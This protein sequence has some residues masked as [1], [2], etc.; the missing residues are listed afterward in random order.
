MQLFDKFE[1]QVIEM[2]EQYKVPVISLPKS[3]SK[4]DVCRSFVQM[5]MAN[6]SLT[7]LEFLTAKFAEDD[8]QIRDDW[9]IRKRRLKSKYPVLSMLELDDFLQAMLLLV[10]QARHGAALTEQATIEKSANISCKREEIIHLKV[11][12]WRNWANRLEKGFE[13]TAQF[14]HEQKLFSGRDLPYQAQLVPLGAIF[15]DL[16]KDG[17]TDGALQKIER[18]F[19]CGVLG[20]LYGRAT[21]SRFAHDLPE[22]VNWVRREDVDEPVT[23]RESNFQ[24]KRLLTLHSRKSPAYK[25]LNALCMRNGC[26][27]LC[28]GRPIEVDVFFENKTDIHHIFPRKWCKKIGNI[29]PEIYD[30]I[31]NKTAISLRTNRQIGCKNP[32]KYIDRLECAAK[33]NSSRMDEILNSH[34]INPGHLRTDNFREFFAD[35]AE[36]LVGSIE[37]ATGKKVEF[38]REWFRLEN[39]FGV[40]GRKSGNCSTQ[41]I[42]NGGPS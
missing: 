35:R 1:S 15:V 18:W 12:D 2:F 22:V 36:A 6:K 10:L 27:D 16:G 28:T 38:Q 11:S 26:L 13:Q 21:A 14:L 4:K 30:S 31:I 39:G 24:A 42:L 23:V 19:W 5:N 8:L 7:S 9:R 20:E 3:I 40:C 41:P 29:P 33:I 25:G 37:K 34:Y 17:K 32:S